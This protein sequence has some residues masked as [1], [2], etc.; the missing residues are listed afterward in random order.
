MSLR[1]LEAL[2]DEG[3]AGAKEDLIR[4]DRQSQCV[5]SECVCVLSAPVSITLLSHSRSRTRSLPQAHELCSS[6]G[7]EDKADEDRDSND[8]DSN[9][10][11]CDSSD[12]PTPAAPG[13]ALRGR[14]NARTCQGEGGW[15]EGREG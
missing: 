12:S 13:P 5:C 9:D 4:L 3:D 2:Q 7:P 14:R 8:M 1:N 11:S 15:R 6:F 10:M